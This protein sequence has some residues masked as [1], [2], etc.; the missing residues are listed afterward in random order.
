MTLKGNLNENFVAWKDNLSITEIKSVIFN[1]GILIIE[2]IKRF[3]L[4]NATPLECMNFLAK[5]KSEM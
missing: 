3:D 4:S 2:K 1:P 5:I